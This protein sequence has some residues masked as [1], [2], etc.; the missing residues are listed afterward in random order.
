MDPSIQALTHLPPRRERVLGSLGIPI[1]FVQVPLLTVQ[2]IRGP[3]LPAI[4]PLPTEPDPDG[5]STWRIEFADDVTVFIRSKPEPED[6]PGIWAVAPNREEVFIQESLLSFRLRYPD[7][8]DPISSD[9]IPNPTVSG[10]DDVPTLLS[11]HSD[12]N[13]CGR[14]C[15]LCQ[16]T[17][18]HSPNCATLRAQFTCSWCLETDGSHELACSGFVSEH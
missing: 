7:P 11:K 2:A 10:P 12:E 3:S 13:F 14:K 5:Q 8:T 16:G 1:Y 17:R 18:H 6:P 15:K 9:E 4:W